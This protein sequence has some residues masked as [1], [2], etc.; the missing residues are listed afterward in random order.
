MSESINHYHRWLGIPPAEQPPHHYRLLGLD[1]FEEDPETI[2]NAFMRQ[3]AY[4]RT[5]QTGSY[6][7]QSQALLNELSSASLCLLNPEQKAVYDSKLRDQLQARPAQTTQAPSSDPA[8]LPRPPRE[9]RSIQPVRMVSSSF[10]TASSAALP[11]VSPGLP[12]LGPRAKSRASSM[13]G[14][15]T[16]REILIGVSL[17]LA[18]LV[19]GVLIGRP[20]DPG[21]STMDASA[22]TGTAQRPTTTSESPPSRGASSSTAADARR[23]TA[24]PRET[25]TPPTASELHREIPSATEWAREELAKVGETLGIT[26]D[27]VIIWNQHHG[28]ENVHGTRQFRVGLFLGEQQVWK[29]TDLELE[30][31]PDVDCSSA[32][33]LPQV[34]FDRLRVEV[35]SWHANGGGLAEIEILR[36][37]VNLARGRPALASASWNDSQYQAQHVTDGVTSSRQSH[38]GYWLL[39]DQTAG[40]IDVDLAVPWSPT[41]GIRAQ[42][43]V[44]WNQHNSTYDDRGTSLADVTLLLNG[45]RA[46][47]KESIP[48][49]WPPGTDGRQEVPLPAVDFNQVRVDVRQWQGIGPGLAEVEVWRDGVNVA[50]GCRVECSTDWSE[51]YRSAKVVDGVA[52]SA[53][54]GVGYWLAEDGQEGWLEI[55]LSSLQQEL[56]RQCARVGAYFALVRGD[57]PR[58]LGWFARSDDAV[59]RQ[60]AE[61]ES[62]PARGSP[63]LLWLARRCLD[64]SLTSSPSVSAIWQS[65]S[66]RY[67]M[68]A[69][70]R[71]T[72][73]ERVETLSRLRA[74]QPTL[75]ERDFLYFHAESCVYGVHA[76]LG[77]R[78]MKITVSGQPSP[79]ALWMHPPANSSSHAVFDLGKRYKALRGSVGIADTAFPRAATALVF[80]IEGDGRKLWTSEP[81]QETG[82]SLAFDVNVAGVERLEIW[83]DCPGPHH[84]A[85]AV[86]LE[87]RLVP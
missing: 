17:L 26:A 40:W 77:L 5:F 6:S 24:T 51:T 44:L 46:W 82:A 72:E 15:V 27:K 75:A 9:Q 2:D 41:K 18:G 32:L 10:S 49:P 52:S 65:R 31:K 57:W 23:D 54:H 11:E 68:Q 78:D 38:V 39:P 86:W 55:D 43:I 60:M 1:L 21:S 81:L 30:W 8:N 83:V 64:L 53:S 19:V 25:P 67:Y 7:A 56:G 87:P 58:G 61:L 59:L 33:A 84:A 12:N 74:A 47:R 50:L 28:A 71:V 76:N 73:L 20:A 13:R 79:N 35:L 16:P 3:M 29:S 4:I 48:L 85:T 42:T 34:K 37:G 45:Q 66:I 36:V 80:R 22:R 70:P 63:D 14:Q 69:L 62:R